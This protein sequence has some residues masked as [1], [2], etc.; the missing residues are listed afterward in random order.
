[1]TTPE[2]GHEITESKYYKF[3]KAKEDP[4]ANIKADDPLKSLNKELGLPDNMEL[5]ISTEHE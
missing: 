5:K 4:F 2:L 3:N 1:M